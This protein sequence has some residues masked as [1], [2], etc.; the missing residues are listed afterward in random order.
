MNDFSFPYCVTC[1]NSFPMREEAYHELERNGLTFY[2][3]C[4]HALCITQNSVASRLQNAQRTI[5]RNNSTVTRLVRSTESLRGVQTRHRNRLLRGHC[6]YCGTSRFKD[7]ITH[8]KRHHN[9]D[10]A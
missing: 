7:L 10:R 1:R 6:P 9:P 8:I 4:G 2:C 5:V 3:P